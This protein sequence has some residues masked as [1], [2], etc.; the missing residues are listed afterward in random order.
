MLTGVLI[1]FGKQHYWEYQWLAAGDSS[2]VNYW[3]IGELS[4]TAYWVQ[5]PSEYVVSHVDDLIYA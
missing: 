4:E 3:V 1:G 2:Q 5:S